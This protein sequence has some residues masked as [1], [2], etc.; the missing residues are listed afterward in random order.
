MQTREVLVQATGLTLGYAR[1]TVLQDLNLSIRAAEFWF[2]LGLNGAGKSTLVRALIGLQYPQAGQLWHHPQLAGLQGV[3]FVPQQ[4]GLNPTLTTTVQE[5]VS[6]GA[7]GT[8]QSRRERRAN[9]HWALRRVGLEA[10]ARRDYWSLSG[11]QQQRALVARALVRRPRLL[12]LDEPTSGFD[13]PTTEAFMHFLATLNR[14]EG[15][16]LFCVTH[17]LPLVVRYATHLALLGHGQALTG[18]AACMLTP[19]VLSRVYGM[20]IT[21]VHQA[22]GGATIHLERPG[23]TAC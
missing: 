6:L 20:P 19:T 22:D 10:L 15:V 11:G 1:R 3:G 5:F 12:V 16:A 8:A 9:Q 17:D 23:E 2:C 21:V 18:A 4:C 13:P 7:V 14:E